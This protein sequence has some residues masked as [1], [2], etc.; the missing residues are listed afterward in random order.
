M[1]RALF[2]LF[3]LFA[4]ALLVLGGCAKQEAPPPSTGTP[5]DGALADVE[6]ID[7]DLNLSEL[8]TLDQDL[9]FG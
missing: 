6:S 1:M 7:Q 9:D 5:N 8:E 4:I 3:A 2:A